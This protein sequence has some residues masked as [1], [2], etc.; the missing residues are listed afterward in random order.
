MA[1]TPQPTYSPDREWTD[2]PPLPNASTEF[3]RTMVSR[4]H[5]VTESG[6]GADGVGTTIPGSLGRYLASIPRQFGLPMAVTAGQETTG[7]G[8]LSRPVAHGFGGG[9]GSGE[10]GRSE[11]LQ[12]YA[13]FPER[14][15]RSKQEPV[16]KGH[17]TKASQ[18]ETRRGRDL[19]SAERDVSSSEAVSRSAGA[20]AGS[21]RSAQP[22]A[23][24]PPVDVAG[25]GGRTQGIRSAN[26]EQQT[27]RPVQR[28]V[29]ATSLASPSGS[30]R[31]SGVSKS[32]DRSIRNGGQAEEPGRGTS[33]QHQTGPAKPPNP[34]DVRQRRADAEADAADRGARADAGR[35]SMTQRAA[36]SSKDS[37]LGVPARL[38]AQRSQTRSNAAGGSRSTAQST[39]DRN[40]VQRS[41]TPIQRS[42]ETASSEGHSGRFGQRANPPQLSRQTQGADAQS[43][44]T[45]LGAHSGLVSHSTVQRSTKSPLSAVTLMYPGELGRGLRNALQFGDAAASARHDFRLGNVMSRPKAAAI[46]LANTKPADNQAGGQSSNSRR[47]STVL[48][49][50]RNRS[51][52]SAIR[53]GKPPFSASISRQSR[54][55][56]SRGRAESSGASI[57]NQS[58]VPNR[59]VSGSSR[60]FSGARSAVQRSAQ[61]PARAIARATGTSKD[62]P[63]V[64]GQSTLVASDGSSGSLA[65]DSSEIGGASSTGTVSS[66]VQIS[67]SRSS[68]GHAV[69]R[70]L[71]PNLAN[72]GQH[73]RVA[74]ATFGLP[75]SARKSR[76]FSSAI[77]DRYALSRN[78]FD[79][80]GSA[81]KTQQSGTGIFTNPP[82]AQFPANATSASMSSQVLAAAG[83]RSRFDASSIPRAA[84]LQR[85][86]EHSP[87]AY[88]SHSVRVTPNGRQQ[89]DNSEQSELV[90][91]AARSFRSATPSSPSQSRYREPAAPAAS[92]STAQSSQPVQRATSAS[93]AELE[94]VGISPNSSP[95]APNGNVSLSTNH[96]TERAG[97]DT[98]NLLVGGPA[99]SANI[100]RRHAS[101]VVQAAI[102]D[103]RIPSTVQSSGQPSLAAANHSG[104]R[105][106]S[107]GT[108]GVHG[109]LA[110]GHTAAQL[111]AQVG[112][113]GSTAGAL[114]ASRNGTPRLNGHSPVQRAALPPEPP[115]IEVPSPEPD[116]HE[117]TEGQLDT[118]IRKLEQRVLSEIE[119]RG[120]RMRGGF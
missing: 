57:R 88:S 89:S 67:S 53:L 108:N 107:A 115:P 46:P 87:A 72:E 95:S 103:A 74:V 59:G 86:V 47:A 26:P 66:R 38:T 117:L 93:P 105:N 85:A 6:D 14:T 16:V 62:S 80:V 7:S 68:R 44:R 37:A 75:A 45:K 9:R 92:V 31:D 119:R 98:N 109:G 60:S 111:S 21:P 70:S 97:M 71:T 65:P 22:A 81:R 83:N 58:V 2:L 32:A 48:G 39:E 18:S 101:Q 102:S 61:T 23:S 28:S 52:R 56:Q 114:T 110:N 104:R 51:E 12:R 82:A 99:A 3:A 27:G 34:D 29:E 90:S 50:A 96:S 4:L 19:G 76:S 116:N 11:A 113:N 1:S 112:S 8:E 40:V 17:V 78:R 84:P 77:S 33:G 35:R 43:T 63:E 36:S 120:G 118:I 20:D 106:G 69:Q 91:P 42:A 64:R 41:V 73:S 5:G 94:A 30:S 13:G 54:D 15:S 24:R 10:R 100:A 79:G 55:L 25:S 49:D